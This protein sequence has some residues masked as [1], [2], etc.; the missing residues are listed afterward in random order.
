[1]SRYEKLLRKI[2]SKPTDF[3]YNE[4]Q[5]LLKALGYMELKKGRTSGS[6]IAFINSKTQH[7]IR[8]HKPHPSRNLK[9]YQ[10]NYIEEEL[11]N[12]G[13]IE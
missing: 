11:K 5:T 10:I 8:L 13:V 7:V 9:M 4:L 2:L 12:T 1:M 6:R 3:T